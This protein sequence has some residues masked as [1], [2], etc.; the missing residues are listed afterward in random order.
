MKFDLL[1]L[2]M[3]LVII[4]P[5]AVAC[6]FSSDTKEKDAY[7]SDSLVEAEAYDVQ[8]LKDQ[9]VQTIVSAPKTSEIVT[10]INTAGASFILDITVPVEK[11]EKSITTTKQSLCVGMYS[12]DIQYAKVYNR[13]DEVIKITE[14]VNQLITKLGLTKELSSF[15][16]NLARIKQHADNKDSVDY[17]VTQNMNYVENQ[18]A[19]SD[20]PDIYALSFIGANI[21][22]LYVISQLTI[23][24]TDNTEIL[25]ILSNQKERVNSIFVL[26][27]LLSGNESVKP[28][29]ES[30]IPLAEFFEEHPAIGEEELNTVTPMIEKIR[31]SML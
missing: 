11:A 22:A 16:D 10:L 26:L 7:D 1:K 23:L 29:Y 14:L 28:Y 18:F 9:I 8:K 15:E 19:S 5:L 12:F 25:K 2:S 17:L 27:K 6:N 3:I 21:E 13:V 30:M 24:A 4:L 31:N 20:H